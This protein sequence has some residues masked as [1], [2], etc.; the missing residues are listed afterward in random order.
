MAICEMCGQ[1][2]C[3]RPCINDPHKT[4]ALLFHADGRAKTLK[5]RG[6]AWDDPPLKIVPPPRSKPRLVEPILKELAKRGVKGGAVT[7]T[8]VTKTSTVTKT[9]SVTKNKG[10]R[11]KSEKPLTAAERARKARA[12]R[13][14]QTSEPK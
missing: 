5:E 8:P 13:K 3:G 12:K 6:L 7:E 2:W 14:T 10:G 11:P 1:G 4:N 9:P